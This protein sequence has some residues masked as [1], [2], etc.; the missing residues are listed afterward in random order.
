MPVLLS[1][2]WRQAN[3]CKHLRRPAAAASLNVV[4]HTAARRAS[5]GPPLL[6]LS[7]VEGPTT[8]PLVE[9]TLS[10]YFKQDILAKHAGRP[11][12]ICKQE[13][14]RH[15]GGPRSHN[16]G[17][18]GHLAWSFG[19]LDE[20]V[21]ALARGLVGLGVKKGDRVGVIMG[22]NRCALNVSSRLMHRRVTTDRYTV[23]DTHITVHTL[24]YNGR[25]P[26]SAPSSLHSTQHTDC[27]NWYASG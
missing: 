26:V 4:P 8:P 10:E 14:P 5:S 3:L 7:Y 6:T 2:R 24:C 25:A 17:V 16:L 13:R 23:P 20:H 1:Q 27:L 11:A 18:E 12:L 21:S 9:S 15:Y 22:N 19:E